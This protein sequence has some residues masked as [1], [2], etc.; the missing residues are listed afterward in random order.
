MSCITLRGKFSAAHFYNNP[1][2]SIDWNQQQFGL[3]YTVYGHGH[4][5]QIEVTV[6][7]DKTTFDVQQLYLQQVL[8]KVEH[9]HLNFDISEFEKGKQIPTCENLCTYFVHLWRTL[10]NELPVKVKV[11]ESPDIWAEWCG[12]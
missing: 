7:A 9:R 12:S 6:K 2:Q 1:T 5:Y 3:C 8:S 10:A 11:S 4:N